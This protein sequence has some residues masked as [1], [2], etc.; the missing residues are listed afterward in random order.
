V[1]LVATLPPNGLQAAMTV[2]GAVNGDVFAAYLSQVLGP[3]L[4]PGDVMIL[5]NLPAHKAGRFGYLGPDGKL[6]T[7]I[8]YATAAPFVQDVA[9]VTTATGQP[10]YLD[11]RGREFWDDK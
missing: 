2:N 7:P 6:L 8:K 1:T 9:R 11:S 4:K 5:D 3:T 10:G